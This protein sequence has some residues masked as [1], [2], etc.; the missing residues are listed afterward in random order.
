MMAPAAPALRLS[1]PPVS[2]YEH[3]AKGIDV[4]LLMKKERHIFI[5][6][7]IHII[8]TYYVHV[9]VHIYKL[10]HAAYRPTGY[11]RP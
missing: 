1:T 9:H 11:A 4:T 5:H 8:L 10:R 6:I 2:W 3:R 7:H